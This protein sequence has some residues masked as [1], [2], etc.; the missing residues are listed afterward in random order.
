MYEYK[1]GVKT[2]CRRLQDATMNFRSLILKSVGILAVNLLVP[3]VEGACE[4]R[5][6]G[7]QVGNYLEEY[8]IGEVEKA[9]HDCVGLTIQG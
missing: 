5:W 6:Y 3:D 2:L 8:L 9:C 4:H 1:V 7:F